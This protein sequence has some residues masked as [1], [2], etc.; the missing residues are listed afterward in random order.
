MEAMYS[1][2]PGLYGSSQMPP[3]KSVHGRPVAALRT[4]SSGREAP[5]VLSFM[6]TMRAI[7]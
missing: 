2:T 5:T 6:T 7:V 4:A 1:A 3:P